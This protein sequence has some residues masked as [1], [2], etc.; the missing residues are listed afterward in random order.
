LDLIVVVDVFVEEPY[1]VVGIWGGGKGEIVG[2]KEK[3]SN[4]EPVFAL[5]FYALIMRIIL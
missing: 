2:G 5:L 1:I 3:E 4:Y